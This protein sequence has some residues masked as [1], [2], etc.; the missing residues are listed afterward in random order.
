M[1]IYDIIIKGQKEGKTIDEINA[2]LKAAGFDTILTDGTKTGNAV[3]V[4]G[5]TNIEIVTVKNGKLVNG[6]GC[7]SADYVIYMGEIYHTENGDNTTLVKGKP[8]PSAGGNKLPKEVDKS[9]RM[10]LIGASEKDRTGIIQHT[11]VGDF[12]CDY[13]E[14]GYLKRAVRA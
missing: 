5:E 4:M 13:K 11:S 3:L 10:D 12:K 14:D 6:A 9:R 8:V 7:G 2:D 1:T